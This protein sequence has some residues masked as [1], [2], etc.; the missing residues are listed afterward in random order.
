MSWG[1]LVEVWDVE[2]ILDDMETQVFDD[3]C[4][5]KIDHAAGRYA[6]DILQQVRRALR[7]SRTHCDLRGKSD[8]LTISG[9]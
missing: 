7:M 9:K 4:D 8:E 5:R 2:N 6:V 1:P 3:L